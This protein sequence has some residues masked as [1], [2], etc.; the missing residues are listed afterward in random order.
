MKA[1][2]VFRRVE[3]NNRVPVK[4][5]DQVISLSSIIFKE[6]HKKFTP[7]ETSTNL[8]SR[9]CEHLFLLFLQNTLMPTLLLFILSF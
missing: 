7:R 5:T 6:L 4:T 9:L 1:R 8:E 2:E 3:K